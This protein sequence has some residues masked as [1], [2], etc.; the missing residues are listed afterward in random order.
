MFA[1]ALGTNVRALSNSYRPTTS[2][3]SKWT[4][5]WIATFESN[6]AR[7]RWIFNLLERI[8]LIWNQFGFKLSKIKDAGKLSDDKN[9]NLEHLKQCGYTNHLVGKWHL[10]TSK[11]AFLPE[12]RGFDTHFGYLNGKEDHFDRYACSK[13]TPQ[14][15]GI[16][17]RDNGQYRNLTDSYSTD[18]YTERIE[19]IVSNHNT[20]KPLFLYAA[21]QNVHFPLEVPDSYLSE[22]RKGIYSSF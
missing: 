19:Q 14:M 15:C 5:S 10:G 1:N 13:S 2:R 22:F 8:D 11:E 4:A 20:S 18:L 6:T 12:N 17:F 21:L 7:K 3:H 9:Q 16:D